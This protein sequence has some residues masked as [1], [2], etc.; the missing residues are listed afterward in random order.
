MEETEAKDLI[1]LHEMTK[2]A[3]EKTGNFRMS[4]RFIVLNMQLEHRARFG[5]SPVRVYLDEPMKDL[6]DDS[7]QQF[8]E[9]HLEKMLKVSES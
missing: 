7:L 4:D 2:I 8:L 6:Y 1:P 5:K 3:R 9:E